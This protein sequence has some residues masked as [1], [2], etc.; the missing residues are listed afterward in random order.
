MYFMHD[1]LMI[2][3]IVV[4]HKNRVGRLFIA[5]KVGGREH[6]ASGRGWTDTTC[7]FPVKKMTVSTINIRYCYLFDCQFFYSYFAGMA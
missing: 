4:N 3:M 6:S 2:L 5:D 1:N 7:L